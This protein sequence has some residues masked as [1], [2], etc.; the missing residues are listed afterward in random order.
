MLDS[1]TFQVDL[2]LMALDADRVCSGFETIL[3]DMVAVYHVSSTLCHQPRVNDPKSG[4]MLG[5]DAID[6]VLTA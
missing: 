6:G 5:L 2:S 1:R 4:L 3:R